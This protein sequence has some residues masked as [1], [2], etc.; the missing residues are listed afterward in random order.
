M[1][2]INGI[3][4]YEKS[5][6]GSEAIKKMNTAIAH[7]GPD[8][9]GI[10][11]NEKAFLGHQRLSII[12]LSDAA[13]QPFYSPDKRYVLVFNGEIYNYQDIKKDL[14]DYPFVTNS[15]TETILAAYLKW[16]KSCVKKFNGMFAFAIYDSVE[17]KLF[18]SR[19]RIGIKPL[20]YYHNDDLLIFSS[21]IRAILK[22]D[23]IPKRLNKSVIAEYLSY[24]CVHAPN[25]I[26]E[27]VKMLLPGHHL[28]FSDE[29]FKI[30]NYW[31]LWQ[32]DDF[33]MP[34]KS[35]EQ[36]QHQIK[37]LFYQAV[38]RRTLA[39]VPMGAFLSGGIDSA[40][41]VGALSEISDKKVNTF[42]VVFDEREFSEAEAAQKMANRFQTHHTEINLKSTDLLESIPIALKAMDHPSGD[43][44]NTYVVSQA[45][46]NAGIT[47]ALS[48]L[49][50]DELFSGYPVFRQME[51]LVNKKW[52]LSYPKFLRRIAGK[53][54][55]QLKQNTASKKTQ[56]ILELDY[57]DLENA[58]PISRQLYSNKE[59]E[60]LLK[61]KYANN[62][63]A[64]IAKHSVS[65]QAPA[66][67]FPY[68]SKISMMEMQTYMTNVLLRD[69]DQ[70]S[71]AHALE[72]R[73]PFL[74][75]QLVQ[76]MMNVPDEFKLTNNP[77][78]LLVKSLGNLLPDEKLQQAKQGFVFPWKEW[79][80]SD[81]RDFCQLRIDSLKHRDFIKPNGLDDMWQR[82]LKGDK[83]VNWSQIWVFVVLENYL[84]ENN[85]H[86]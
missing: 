9:E 28:H 20:Y 14:S 1:C 76:Y 38:E 50:G 72:I 86:D 3:F 26:I 52:L 31:N 18:I 61:D 64:Q 32:F 70:M 23:L 43:G 2:G 78:E 16:G 5:Q 4:F 75:H 49:G 6:K 79:L 71:M 47:V 41:I 37:N 44:I 8:A 53:I 54:N 74:D 51:E 63:I 29:E 85:I 36:H 35:I 80:K 33:T 25:T 59:L 19:D 15:D 10:Y 82:F 55:N 46:K 48:G 42:T 68:Q 60:Y 56:S 21:E 30:E 39:D 22:S 77:K 67:D 81:L 73:V 13:N 24:Q 7:R 40:A 57:F 66:F 69:A 58:Y 83:N 12:D 65:F 84:Q 62:A 34:N 45:T 27:G 11:Q 17:N